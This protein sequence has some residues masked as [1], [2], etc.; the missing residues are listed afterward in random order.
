MEKFKMKLSTIKIPD[1]GFSLIEVVVALLI[2]SISVFSIYNLIISTASSSYDLEQK[3]LAKEVAN[4]RIALINT[5]EKPL[6]PIERN[7][8]MKMGGKE[9]Y[10]KENIKQS[11]DNDF[12][13]YEILVRDINE[14]NYIYVIKG[15]IDN[16]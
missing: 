15:F 13:E 16:A 7:G 3:Y 11:T 14:E 5:I 10:W 6:R 2:L 9:W 1:K 12:Y 8:L 4:N